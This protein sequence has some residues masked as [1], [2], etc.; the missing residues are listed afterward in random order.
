MPQSRVAQSRITTTFNNPINLLIMAR[1]VYVFLADGFE[2][3]EAITTIDLLRRAG[4]VVRTVAIGNSLEVSGAH[5]L[6][7]RADLPWSDIDLSDADALVLPGGLPGVTNLNAFE[8]LRLA[9]KAHAEA[10]KLVGAICAAPMV[11]GQL[12]LLKGQEATCYPSFEV[13]LEGY[14]PTTEAVVRSGNII[15]ARSA[16]VSIDFA[17]ALITALI[18]ADEAEAVASAIIYQR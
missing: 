9:L 3:I 17:L 7:V 12:G 16:G 5:H 10:G 6:P 8:P 11:L 1:N 14:T 15:T 2:E 4:L 13:H 18:G